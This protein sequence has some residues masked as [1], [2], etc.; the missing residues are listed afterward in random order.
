MFTRL[1]TENPVFEAGKKNTIFL[2]SQGMD[3]D[4]TCI[5]RNSNKV[6]LPKNKMTGHKAGYLDLSYSEIK[7]V[8]IYI[9]TEII[10]GRFV[11]EM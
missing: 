2:F 7:N 3:Y 9:S 1:T 8:W 6:R 10:N 4:T 11:T 5:V